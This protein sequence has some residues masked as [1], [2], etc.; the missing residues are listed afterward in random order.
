MTSEIAKKKAGPIQT[1]LR[2]G[3]AL[4]S[5]AFPKKPTVRQTRHNDMELL[6]WANEYI[7]QRV[8][9]VGTFE[10]EEIAEFPK[11]L[12]VGDVCIDVGANIGIHT[13]SLAKAVG[14][15]GHV[16][17]FEPIRKNALIVE[18][19]AI[20]NGFEN[21]TVVTRPLSDTAGKKL[22]P[23]TPAGDSAY[24]FFSE[25][26]TTPESGDHNLTTT[27]D[28]Y[29]AV[30]SITGVKFI[31][32][33]VEGAELKVLC[34]ASRLLLSH[35]RPDIIVTEMVNEYLGRFGD[36]V[37]SVCGFMERHNYQPH[38]LQQGLLVP[39]AVDKISIQNVYFKK[40]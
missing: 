39:V 16:H 18:L 3:M 17:A 36:S 21:V 23:T 15:R 33:D 32:I 26:E 24:T 25:A 6:V 19:N 27:I 20:L 40:F 13:L 14:P 30:H 38:L 37:D 1:I 9:T 10:K 29:C 22:A 35:N 4:T 28:E 5:R 8:L 7:G 2:T 34:G 11:M 31:K 12:D